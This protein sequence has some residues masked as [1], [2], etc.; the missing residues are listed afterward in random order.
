MVMLLRRG[1]GSGNVYRITDIASQSIGI[2][3][4]ESYQEEE[5]RAGGGGGGFEIQSRLHL[6]H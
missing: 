3:S 5:R 1:I 4:I 6:T 2:V